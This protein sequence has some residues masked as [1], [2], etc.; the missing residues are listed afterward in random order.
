MHLTGEEV[1]VEE[2][3]VVVEEV[4]VEVEIINETPHHSAVSSVDLVPPLTQE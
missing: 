4:V 2:E 3:E 1:A